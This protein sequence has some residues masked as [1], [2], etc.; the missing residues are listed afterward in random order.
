MKKYHSWGEY[1]DDQPKRGKEMLETVRDIFR[2]V[3]PDAIE[4][5][6][7]GVPAYD[8]VPNAKLEQK[9]MFAGF[10]KHIGIYPTPDT[11]NAFKEELADF[12]TSKGTVQI[13]HSQ[14]IPVE[15]IKKMILHRYSEIQKNTTK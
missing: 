6:S 11:I 9:I 5:W 10:K 3:L 8:L 12:K 14:E 4:S 15:L 13:Q 7:Y 2:E 1:F